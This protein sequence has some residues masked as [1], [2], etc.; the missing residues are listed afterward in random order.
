M[1]DDALRQM[2]RAKFAAGTLPLTPPKRANSFPGVRAVCAV[3]DGA[4]NTEE[5][6]IEADSVDGQHWV[7]HIGCFEVLSIERRRASSA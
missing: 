1:N 3:C 4:I 2:I 6:E 5:W 7:F